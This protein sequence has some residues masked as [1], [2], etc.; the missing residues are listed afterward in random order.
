MQWIG[1]SGWLQFRQSAEGCVAEFRRRAWVDKRLPLKIHEFYATLPRTREPGTFHARLWWSVH[2][3]LMKGGKALYLGGLDDRK[4]LDCGAT[5]FAGEAENHSQRVQN[6]KANEVTA[7]DDLFT[8]L[9]GSENP[10]ES[11]TRWLNSTQPESAT[12]CRTK[13]S[14]EMDFLCKPL[15]SPNKKKG[16][17]MVMCPNLDGL[18]SHFDA[19]LAD[20]RGLNL[21]DCYDY[22]R[23]LVE[24]PIE[25]HDKFEYSWATCTWTELYWACSRRPWRFSSPMAITLHLPKGW[26]G[27]WILFLSPFFCCLIESTLKDSAGSSW[28]I[29]A[30][31]THVHPSIGLIY[32][33]QC[34]S[35]M[36]FKASDTHPFCPQTTLHFCERPPTHSERLYAHIQIWFGQCLFVPNYTKISP[37][38][39]TRWSVSTSW[40]PLS[41]VQERCS[42][43]HTYWYQTRL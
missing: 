9:L 21:Q 6:Q 28:T 37:S 38:S 3:I 15:T 1:P 7:T 11:T 18:A 19:E 23:V 42:T 12:G 26:L 34:F 32:I 30:G 2:G 27:T 16:T 31:Q 8:K 29:Q 40:E 10:G 17:L 43:V 35:A 39:S 41:A 5:V 33:T 36:N 20:S 24:D 13:Q 22:A 4:C 25:V 14:K